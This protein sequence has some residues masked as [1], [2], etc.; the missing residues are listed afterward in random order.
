LDF[1]SRQ[2]I[3][4]LIDIDATLHQIAD[5]LRRAQSA[6]LTL[7]PIGAK[8]LMPATIHIN[9]NGAQA[10]FVEFDGPNGTGNQVPPIGTIAFASDN[11]AV[12]TVDSTGKVTAVGVGTCNISG[13]DPGNSLTASDSL[14]VSADVAVSATLTLT[15]L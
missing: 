6:T 7:K 11:P 13:T 10:A 14:T 9:G 4:L 2:E 8:Y 1:N 15:A 5:E 3:E 12:A